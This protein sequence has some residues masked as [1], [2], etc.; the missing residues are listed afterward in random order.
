MR[1][2]RLA[3]SAELDLAEIWLHIARDNPSAAD[4]LVDA[5]HHR[6]Q[7]L[8]LQPELGQARPDIAAGD[9]RCF[10]VGKYIIFTDPW[11]P[12]SRSPESFTALVTSRL[13]SDIGSSLRLCSRSSADDFHE[14]GTGP[15]SADGARRTH[16]GL[17][18]LPLR[19]V[20]NLG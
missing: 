8:A 13:C 9:L 10:T 4:R 16:L 6:F 17:P 20:A 14:K 5:L 3:P 15:I 19:A 12:A 11:M 1:L 7:I 18:S 2:F